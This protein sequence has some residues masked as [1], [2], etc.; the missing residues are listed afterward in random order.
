M[1]DIFLLCAP[2]HILIEIESKGATPFDQHILFVNEFGQVAEIGTKSD[3]EKPRVAGPSRF[4][5]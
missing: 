1:S 3:A 5:R 2:S 4:K